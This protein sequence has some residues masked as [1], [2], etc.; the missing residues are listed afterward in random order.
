MPFCRSLYTYLAVPSQLATLNL[1]FRECKRGCNYTRITDQYLRPIHSIGSQGYNMHNQLAISCYKVCSYCR[2]VS[3]Q[4][5]KIT[6]PCF[7]PP[8]ADQRK[9]LRV[10]LPCN[11]FDLPALD[12]TVDGWRFFRRCRVTAN[13]SS[14]NG[15]RVFRKSQDAATSAPP[16]VSS[17]LGAP[18]EWVTLQNLDKYLTFVQVLSKFCPIFVQL[19][20]MS[21]ICQ[22]N[23]NFTKFCQILVHILS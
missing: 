4:E 8:L 5:T 1:P 13:R 18:K 23:L 16:S 10:M 17:R 15:W 2:F 19:L 9:Y 6:W 21:S 12:S 7:E 3:V 22:N 11:K 20:S 14:I